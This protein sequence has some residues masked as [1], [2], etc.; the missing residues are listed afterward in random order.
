MKEIIN[1]ARNSQWSFWIFFDEFNTS[2]LQSIICEMMTDRKV[3]GLDEYI[4]SNVVLISACNPYRIKPPCCEAGLSSVR[5]EM[6]LSHRVYPIPDS[7]I[8][9][10]INFAQLDS[11]V[12]TSYIDK[13]LTSKATYMTSLT[14]E[15]ITR[16]L[17]CSH[18][19]FRKSEG[20]S[21]VSLRD[22]RR[23]ID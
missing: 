11:D 6:V 7:C 5:E 18:A 21:S 17:K 4:P 14:K 19:E 13:L 23:F 9:N 8:R 12:E 15:C 22:I 20:A 1:G 10:A 16:C 2:R 3:S